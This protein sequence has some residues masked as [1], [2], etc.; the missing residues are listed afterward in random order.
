M[1]SGS[2]IAEPSEVSAPATEQRRRRSRTDRSA[3]HPERRRD[4]SEHQ[5]ESE[6]RPGTSPARHRTKRHA[7]ETDRQRRIA[8]TAETMRREGTDGSSSGWKDSSRSRYKDP[9]MWRRQNRPTFTEFKKSHGWDEPP[10]PPLQA[11]LQERRAASSSRAE[12]RTRGRHSSPSASASAPSSPRSLLLSGNRALAG[13]VKVGG[14][15]VVFGATETQTFSVATGRRRR[16]NP[17]GGGHS[18]PGWLR[19]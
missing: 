15:S 2:S 5:K 14:K 8:E 19:R 3:R 1:G 9:Q 10:A 11:L 4:K 18:E 17:R 12:R 13:I 6:H 7:E 16:S